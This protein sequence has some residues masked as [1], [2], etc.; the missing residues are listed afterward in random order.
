MIDKVMRININ[1]KKEM[2]YLSW[3]ELIDRGQPVAK[4]EEDQMNESV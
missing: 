1:K 2:P 4:D 3:I